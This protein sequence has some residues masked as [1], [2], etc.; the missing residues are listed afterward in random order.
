[1]KLGG[2]GANATDADAKKNS[3]P[4]FKSDKHPV[5]KGTALLDIGAPAKAD[6]APA[7]PSK[8]GKAKGLKAPTKLRSSTTSSLKRVGAEQVDVSGPA[9][10]HDDDPIGA[11]LK[12]RVAAGGLNN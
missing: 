5:L 6:A 2:L 4:V 10:S 9:V 12:A 3:Y 8:L 11:S 1:M 7:S